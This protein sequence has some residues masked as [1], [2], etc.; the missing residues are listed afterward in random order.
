MCSWVTFITPDTPSARRARWK[1]RLGKE[2]KV[3]VR[4]RAKAYDGFRVA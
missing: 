2:T 1:R 4:D 3:G